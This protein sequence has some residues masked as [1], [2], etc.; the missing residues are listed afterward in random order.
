IAGLDQVAEIIG[1]ER[2]GIAET[3]A[4]R[5]QEGVAAITVGGLV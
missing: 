4:P 3:V 1:E 2:E 5:Q